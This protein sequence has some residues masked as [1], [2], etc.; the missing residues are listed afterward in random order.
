MFRM[1]KGTQGVMKLRELRSFLVIEISTHA[2]SIG[3]Y[4]ESSNPL[5]TIYF[6]NTALQG[7]SLNLVPSFTHS[8]I[9]GSHA[10]QRRRK[11]KSVITVA[12]EG[13]GAVDEQ[14]K[15]RKVKCEDRAEQ[16]GQRSG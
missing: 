16:S 7:S 9:A 14:W 3:K 11:A 13:S 4:Q 10:V 8:S 1:V 5:C 15:R 12:G 2:G 6:R